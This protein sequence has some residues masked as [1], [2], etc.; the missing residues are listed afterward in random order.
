[1][2]ACRDLEFVTAALSVHSDSLCSGF[3]L[4]VSISKDLEITNM[5]LQH[6]LVQMT[7]DLMPSSSRCESVQIQV[8]NADGHVVLYNVTVRS[9]HLFQ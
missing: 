5:N 2:N 7:D 1:M 8:W 9:F 6:L 3:L 4:I